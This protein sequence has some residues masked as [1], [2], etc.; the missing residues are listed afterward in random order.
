MSRKVLT[1]YTRDDLLRLNTPNCKRKPAGMSEISEIT[2]FD[3]IGTLFN[4]LN[5]RSS[6]KPEEKPFYKKDDI[7]PNGASMSVIG[8]C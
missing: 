7:D 2:K 5:N 1:K 8:V 4:N 6:C 3:L